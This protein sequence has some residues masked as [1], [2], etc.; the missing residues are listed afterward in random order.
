MHVFLVTTNR[1]ASFSSETIPAVNNDWPQDLCS[2]KLLYTT[3]CETLPAPKAFGHFWPQSYWTRP[4]KV[5][6]L[7]HFRLHDKSS[8]KVFWTSL[9]AK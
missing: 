3:G 5:V 8:L 9:A 7:R 2:P 4:A 6:T 1:K